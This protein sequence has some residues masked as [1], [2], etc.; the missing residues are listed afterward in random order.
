MVLCAP[1]ALI[2]AC[3]ELGVV[4]APPAEELLGVCVNIRAV[5]GGGGGGEGKVGGELGATGPY[6]TNTAEFRF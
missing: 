3:W 4:L 5:Q 6:M 2:C 1:W